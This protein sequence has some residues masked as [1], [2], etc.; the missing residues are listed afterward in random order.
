MTLKKK[1]MLIPFSAL[2]ICAVLGALPL[3]DLIRAEYSSNPEGAWRGLSAVFIFF[4]L[5]AAIVPIGAYILIKKSA[6]KS[7]NK[8]LIIKFLVLAIPMT[9]VSFP[10]L[11]FTDVY[12]LGKGVVTLIFMSMFL[13][14]V[15]WSKAQELEQD[16]RISF[17]PGLKEGID[18]FFYIR[19]ARNKE[20]STNERRGR[21]KW[22]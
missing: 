4:Y 18:T 16:L 9:L 15:N 21:K 22:D 13:V 12:P 10:I 7:I 8:V 2:L 6:D 1:L 17:G 5:L 11:H 20:N 14:M 19:Q 3:I